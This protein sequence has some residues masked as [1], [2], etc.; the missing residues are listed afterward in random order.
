ME[1][2]SLRI[3]QGERGDGKKTPSRY[4]SDKQRLSLEKV[5]QGF[6]QE[7]REDGS[8][9]WSRL[10]SPN[11]LRDQEGAVWEIWV[12]K[13]RQNTLEGWQ[14]WRCLSGEQEFGWVDIAVASCSKLPKVPG[15]PDYETAQIELK[16]G[17]LL[18]IVKGGKDI[19][20]GGKEVYVQKFGEN[21]TMEEVPPNLKAVVGAK[22]T[23]GVVR[24]PQIA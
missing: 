22:A 24:D 13:E 12:D 9:M 11:G 21:E 17:G 5:R 4:L 2:P 6:E 7:L 20:K 8:L 1:K 10:T 18:N 3:I 19:V 16:D 14:V 15:Y 23:A